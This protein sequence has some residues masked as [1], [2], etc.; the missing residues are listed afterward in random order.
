[1]KNIQHRVHIPNL[2]IPLQRLYFVFSFLCKLATEL[3]ERLELIDELVDD[4]PEPLIGQFEV[5]GGL[6]GEDVVEELA[7]VVV[8]LESLLNSGTTL[9]SSID[10]AEVELP[11]QVEEDWI[12]VDIRSHILCLWP[13]RRLEELVSEL[14]EGSLIQIVHFINVP[15][16]DHILEVLKKLLDWLWHSIVQPVQVRV[17]SV[18]IPTVLVF[19]VVILRV[20][21]DFSLVE[22]NQAIKA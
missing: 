8:A 21:L 9:V 16:L 4:L 17:S 2:R 10:V 3:A 14:W 19:V 12:I 1:M 15:F 7:V 11:V 22:V 20:H 13:W 5:D 6:R 18:S